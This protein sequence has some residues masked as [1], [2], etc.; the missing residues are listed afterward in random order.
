MRIEAGEM[1]KHSLVLFWGFG[2]PE[3]RELG[4]K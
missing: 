3:E 2:N 1:W 4:D